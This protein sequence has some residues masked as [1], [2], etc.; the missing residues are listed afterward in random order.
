MWIMFGA[1]AEV[2]EWTK[3]LLNKEP[4]RSKAIA[5]LY[6]KFNRL[7]QNPTSTQ[8]QTR[9]DI[10]GQNSW[11]RKFGVGFARKWNS[12]PAYKKSCA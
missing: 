8:I 5:N 3:F 4:V 9:D 7:V 2:A 6:L 12:V 1:A 11:L 10:F